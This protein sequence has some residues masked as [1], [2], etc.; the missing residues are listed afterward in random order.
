MFAASAPAQS[1]GDLE[2]APFQYLAQCAEHAGR[3]A[4]P[5]AERIDRIA[6]GDQHGPLALVQRNR[7]AVLPLA[8]HRID[9]PVEQH[10]QRPAHVAPIAGRPDDQGVGPTNRLRRAV[11]VVLRQHATPQRT[12]FHTPGAG[13]DLHVADEQHLD[14][15]PFGQSAGHMAEHL[16]NQPVAA[17]TSV[18][19]DDFHPSAYP[20]D[21]S[22]CKA[23]SFCASTANSIGSF[24]NTSRA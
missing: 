21:P 24:D 23:S 20:T 11:G 1:P 4:E 5:H 18:Y 2:T 14:F 10:L 13:P 16:R 19:D 6:R 17:G 15:A 9:H 7:H 12:A 22:S 3:L 8:H